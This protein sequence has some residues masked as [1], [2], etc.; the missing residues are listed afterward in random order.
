MVAPIRELGNFTYS[1]TAMSQLF[2]NL[3]LSQDINMAIDPVEAMFN[4]NDKFD[5]VRDHPL[6]LSIHRPRSLSLLLLVSNCDEEYHVHVQRESNKIDENK[7]INSSG[8]VELEYV[9]P[10]SQPNQVSKAVDLSF[11]MRQQYAPTVSSTLNQLHGKD[12]VNIHL[13]YDPNQA[14]DLEF[15]N[16]NF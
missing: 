9:T 16:S 12:I 3:V 10:K 11:N 13:N 5:E 2:S 14:L 6:D 15:W 4:L 1:S 7:P 8:N